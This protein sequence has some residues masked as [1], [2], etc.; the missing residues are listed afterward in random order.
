VH[1]AATDDLPGRRVSAIVVHYR[2]PEETLRSVRALDAVAGVEVL[3]VD[4]A[5]GDGIRPLLAERAPGARLV[6]LEENRGYGAACNRGAAATERPYLLFLN[7]DAYVRPGAVESLV[8]ALD[9]DPGAAAAGPR[10]LDPDGTLQ[11]SIRRLPT[12]W[13]I[14]CE[15]SGLAFF[16]GG[17]GALAGHTATRQDHGRPAAVEALMGAALLVR[18][19]AF[20]EVGGFDESFFLYAEETDLMARWRRRG[21]RVLYEPRAEVVHEGGRS[22]GDRLFG[23][24]HASLVRY[25]EKHHGATASRLV[26]AALD[27]GALLR[28]AAAAVT[29]GE[30]GDSRRRRYRAALARGRPAP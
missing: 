1:S 9:A 12:P 22:G 25:T 17:R 8:A 10:L 16:S 30:R 11:R 7:S 2:T 23:Q 3:V 26:G 13:R 24:L 29:P 19:F 27:A 28:Y 21:W 15:S 20:E 4:N 6:P 18:R 5:S 14:F